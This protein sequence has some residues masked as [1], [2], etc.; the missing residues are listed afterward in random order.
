MK[1]TLSLLLLSAAALSACHSVDDDRIPQVDVYIPFNSQPEWTVYGVAGACDHKRFIKQERIPANFPYQAMCYTGYGGV[2]LCTDI[3]GN[4]IAY[5]L[6]C[7]V[8][9]NPTVRVFIDTENLQ[10]ECPVCHSTYDVFSNN[11]TPTGGVAA[12]HGYGLRRYRV[13]AGAAGQYMIVTR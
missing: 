8:E 3:H 10:A 2:L 9:V 11:G 7:P 4:P 13:G 12:S 1:K 6:A 5:D